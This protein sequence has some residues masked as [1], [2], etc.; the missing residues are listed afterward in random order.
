M[1][2]ATT[3][4]GV[5]IA[6]DDAGSGETA[7]LCLP[8]WCIERSVFA[9][10]VARA[11]EGRRVL[12]LDW[13]GHGDSSSPDGDFRESELL[14]DAVAVIEASSV[15]RVVPVAQAH[16][17][18]VAI[19]LAQRLGERVPA[20]V[21]CSWMMLAP[22]PPFAGALAS[23][24]DPQS[25]TTTRDKLV[26]MWLEGGPPAVR[27]AIV[28]MTTRSGAAMWSRGARE[29]AAAFARH[30]TACSA[31]SRLT[32]VRPMLHLYAQP[33][34]PEV[35][36]AHEGIAREHAWFRFRRLEGS[37]HFPTLETPDTV[38]DAIDG[39]LAV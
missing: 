21:A 4:G 27:E 35:L 11:R 7:L 31:L 15:A 5:R 2:T 32:P 38:L 20:I 17:G 26:G 1:P 34:A 23:L 36:A 14:E 8:G 19:A 10:L 30:G 6:Y 28:A 13:R 25:W 33:R 37:T 39:L 16:A 3:Q 18:W 24:Q 9:P 12:A 29:I 22:P